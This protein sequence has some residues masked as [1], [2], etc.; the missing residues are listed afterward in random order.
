M[1]AIATHTITTIFEKHGFLLRP[2]N[3]YILALNYSRFEEK[4]L[5]K[6]DIEDRMLASVIIFITFIYKPLEG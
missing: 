5:K 6:F 4:L 1:V 2:I 3:V